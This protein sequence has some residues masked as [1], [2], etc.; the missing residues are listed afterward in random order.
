[1]IIYFIQ[2][3]VYLQKISLEKVSVKLYIL[4]SLNPISLYFALTSRYH[5]NDRQKQETKLKIA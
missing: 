5:I 3:G 4:S 1:M 2:K